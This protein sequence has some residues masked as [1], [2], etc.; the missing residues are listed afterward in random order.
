MMISL[1]MVTPM[2]S[3]CERAPR[4]GQQREAVFGDCEDGEEAGEHLGEA[5]VPDA[6]GD[7]YARA[8]MRVHFLEQALRNRDGLGNLPVG[9]RSG[10]DPP[11]EAAAQT[12]PGE[13]H[14]HNHQ[15]EGEDPGGLIGGAVEG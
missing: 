7:A 14:D 13:Q 5:A 1:A 9:G 6:A 8:G 2:W 3:A 11:L 12:T 15:E 10:G 4:S